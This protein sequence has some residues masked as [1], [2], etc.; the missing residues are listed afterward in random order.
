MTWLKCDCCCKC[1]TYSDIVEKYSHGERYG[2][3]YEGDYVREECPF[4]G[5]ADFGEVEDEEFEDY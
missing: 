1:F 3:Q 5:S 2:D 4:C